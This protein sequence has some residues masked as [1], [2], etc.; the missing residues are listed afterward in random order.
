MSKKRQDS[1]PLAPPRE[2]LGFYLDSLLMDVPGETP[3][4]ISR[5]AEPPAET[6]AKS[7]AKRVTES[8]EAPSFQ[9][10]GHKPPANNVRETRTNPF[11]AQSPGH[12][13]A[14]ASVVP[15]RLERRE[16]GSRPFAEPPRP[17]SLLSGPPVI[18]LLAT[19]V[20]AS[21]TL[22]NAAS[23]ERAALVDVSVAPQVEKAPT[24]SAGNM[25]AA[26]ETPEETTDKTS[27]SAEMAEITAVSASVLQ[28]DSTGSPDPSK[29]KSSKSPPCPDAPVWASHRFQCLSF[30]VAGVTLATPLEKLHG[31]IEWQGEITAL[32]GYVP[33]FMGLQPNRGQN[34]RVIDTAQIIMPDGRRPDARPA[35]ERVQY[36]VLIDDGRWGLAVDAIGEVLALEPDDIRWRGERSKRPW[37]AGTAVEQMCAVLDIDS[38]SEQLTQG[39][40]LDEE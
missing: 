33:W 30:M 7:F 9:K 18:P 26:D 39:L 1:K 28:P 22:K 25:D 5:A 8:S 12:D 24:S 17:Q 2:A 36:V 20:A 6:S 32:P 31:I 40:K 27:A 15:L 37:L 3:D 10:S 11:P 14:A 35:L 13:P 4:E 23:V 16:I 38:L 19:D 29:A 21:V 34:V